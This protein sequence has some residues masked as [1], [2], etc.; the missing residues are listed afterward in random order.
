M[1]IHRFKNGDRFAAFAKFVEGWMYLMFQKFRDPGI[2]TVLTHGPNASIL[3][4][5]AGHIYIIIY[6][7]IFNLYII[8]VCMFL[9]TNQLDTQCGFIN[10]S[11]STW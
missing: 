8:Y 6:I 11:L 2:C 4:I 1:Y 3:Y 10:F 9:A 5:Y 7:Y